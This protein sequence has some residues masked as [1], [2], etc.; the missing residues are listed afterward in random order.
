MQQPRLA[1]PGHED[2][3]GGRNMVLSVRG[4]RPQVDHAEIGLALDDPVGE[5]ERAHFVRSRRHR[6]RQFLGVDRRGSALVRIAREERERTERER[7]EREALIQRKVLEGSHLRHPS[8]LRAAM[9]FSTHSAPTK[10]PSAISTTA[11][12]SRPYGRP[13][14]CESVS[15]PIGVEL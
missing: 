7:D 3:L 8:A 11:K 4:F 6:E 1:K 2:V 13:V 14:T 15:C 9:R 12:T 5:R 10:P